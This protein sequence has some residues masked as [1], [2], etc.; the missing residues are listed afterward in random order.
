MRVVLSPHLDDAVLSC[1]AQLTL[2]AARVITIFAGVPSEAAPATGWDRVCGFESP[3]EHARVRL[4]EDERVMTGL[5]VDAERWGFVDYPNAAYG[6]RPSPLALCDL[7]ADATSAGDEL[8]A[9]VSVLS[10]SP[11]PDHLLVREAMIGCADRSAMLYADLPHCLKQVGEWPAPII[12]T[13]PEPPRAWLEHA[14]LALT[15]RATRLGTFLTESKAEAMRAY[16]SQFRPLGR[17]RDPLSRR[18]LRRPEVY[19]VEVFWRLS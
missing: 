11:H 16:A 19:G 8:W 10:P 9:P 4:A 1:F 13:G 5:G 17:L 2:G 14:A 15:A 3:A 6:P 12:P 18:V 7:I